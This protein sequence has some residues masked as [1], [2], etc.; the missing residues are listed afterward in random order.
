VVTEE[1]GKLR[2][3]VL[4]VYKVNAGQQVDD[5]VFLVDESDKLVLPIWIGEAEA[6]SIQL[7]LERVKPQRPITHDLIV[8]ML[9]ELKFELEKITIDGLI[10]GVYTATLYL[11]DL[12]EDRVL[13]IDARPSDSLAIALRTGCQIYADKSLTDN[14]I[15]KS[16]LKLPESKIDEGQQDEETL[17]RRF[18]FTHRGSQADQDDQEID[19][20]YGT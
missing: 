4:G 2:M 9:D 13:K 20:P 15:P 11:K 14:M 18:G 3:G 1:N 7:A 16:S 12:R 6:M 19:S 5:V 8:N 10:K 17:G